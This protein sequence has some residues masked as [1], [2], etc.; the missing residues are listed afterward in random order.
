MAT[1]QNEGRQAQTQPAQQ[2]KEQ[3]AQDQPAQPNEGQ[4]APPQGETQ[5]TGEQ[6]SQWWQNPKVW[7]VVVLVGIVLVLLSLLFRI[8]LGIFLVPLFFM[9]MDYWSYLTRKIDKPDVVYDPNLRI[10][11]LGVILGICFLPLSFSSTIEKALQIS[12]SDKWGIPQQLSVLV[13]ILLIIG[14]AFLAVVKIVK[15]E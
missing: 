7:I 12:S 15:E 8:T 1:Q 13:F 2:N 5:G 10:W 4:Q 3:G 14:F 6:A 11:G 9:V